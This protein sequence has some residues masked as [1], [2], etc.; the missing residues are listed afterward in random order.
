MENPT[1][2]WIPKWKPTHYHV[3]GVLMYLRYIR[4]YYGEEQ[5]IAV[6]GSNIGNN[7]R[8]ILSSLNYYYTSQSL[9]VPYTE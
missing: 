1:M 6:S 9:G 4:Q 3:G 7:T 8:N 2:L 5:V